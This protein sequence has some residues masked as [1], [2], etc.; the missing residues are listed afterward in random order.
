[1]ETTI[2]Q[3]IGSGLV[4]ENKDENLFFKNKTI[5]LK[6]ETLQVG[7]FTNLNG[8]MPHPLRYVGV[9]LE[10]GH[11]YI[12]FHIGRGA[13]LFGFTDYY[14]LFAVIAPSRL[15]KMFTFQSG[16]DFNWIKGAWR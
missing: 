3:G 8:L 2:I 9:F 6:S 14:S 15:F 16:R 11:T 12:S 7:S 5:E 13:D 10:N 4:I 1:M